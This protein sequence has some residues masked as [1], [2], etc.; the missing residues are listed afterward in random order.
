MADCFSAVAL[1]DTSVDM[2]VTVSIRFTYVLD[3]SLG[4]SNALT[5]VLE[6]LHTIKR[7]WIWLF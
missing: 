7:L 1:F 5:R 4:Y 6:W 2:K 3:R